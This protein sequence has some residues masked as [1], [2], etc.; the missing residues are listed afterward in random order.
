[1]LQSYIFFPNINSFAPKLTKKMFFFAKKRSYRMQFRE[2]YN[3]VDKETA[4]RGR[5]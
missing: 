2:M 3:S 1:M 5:G 4:F